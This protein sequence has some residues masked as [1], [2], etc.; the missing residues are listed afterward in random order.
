VSTKLPL[1]A[2]ELYAEAKADLARGGGDVVLKW[3]FW[4]AQATARAV[5]AT[6]ATKQAN[7][8]MF[9]YSVDRAGGTGGDNDLH[10]QLCQSVIATAGDLAEAKAVE[11]ACGHVLRLA[12]RGVK[13]TAAK[14]AGAPLK[15]VR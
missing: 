3:A 13:V 1:T 10:D 6:E 14:P 5:K 2:R 4:H 11:V 15:A 9:R 7:D 8:R 12:E